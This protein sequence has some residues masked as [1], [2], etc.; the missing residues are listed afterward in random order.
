MI[1]HCD[2]SSAIRARLFGAFVAAFAISLA[3]P[4]QAIPSMGRQT[5]MQCASCHTV[6]P[7]LTPFGRQ[8]KLGGF[9][10]SAPK[11]PD[12]SVFD[13][14]P[15]SALVQ[16]SWTDTKNTG[17]EGATDDN[18]PRNRETILQAA[19]FYYGGKIYDNLGALV[20]YN[21]D[22][23]ERSWAM[24]MFDMRYGNTTTVAD[25]GL[26]WGVSMNN[27]PTLSDIYNSTPVWSF[28]HAGSPAVMPAASTLID[29]TLGSQVGGL[30][31]Y[32]LWDD[33]V[34]AELGGYRTNNSGFFRFMGLGVTKNTIVSGT[35]P[36]WRL[37]LQ[38]Q[39]GDHGFEVGTYGMVANVFAD[40]A[41]LSLGTNRFRDVALDAQ[42]QYITDEHQVSA[43]TTW[44][45]EKQDWK[46]SFDQGLS[47]SPSTT[48]K[49]FRADL[50]YFYRRLVGGGVQY[51]Q[52][53][54]DS[55]DLLYNT[56]EPVMGSANGS[57]NS[58]G[59]VA[60]VNWLPIQN[61]KLAVRYTAYQQF[62]GASSNYD[63][64][65]RNAK[66]NNSIFLLAWLL[67]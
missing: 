21:F 27:S 34:Y 2:F 18:F 52:T 48:L 61:V 59:W 9:S 22:G 65:G 13:V 53:R 60:E 54:G 33:T 40:S 51:F 42:Y 39:I 20:Q 7:E 67:L 64:F 14:I 10:L 6:F 46:T 38:K 62:N 41:D 36:Y 1:K 56:G 12:A 15:V 35:A 37:A 49:T 44:I 50:H 66:D 63:G 8:F 23:V 4:V 19:G 57:P 47:S 26:F 30:T 32:G 58:N 24:E 55:N 5:G 31:A 43:H 16:V 25:K 17:T 3:M 29:T 11:G 45:R 28:P